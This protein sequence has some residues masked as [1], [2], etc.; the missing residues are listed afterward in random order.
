[1]SVCPVVG[2]VPCP[3]PPPQPQANV[4][5]Q[6][7]EPKGGRSNDL[8]RVRGWGGGDQFGRL[9]GK[10][11]T[12]Y[13]LLCGNTSE[14]DDDLGEFLGAGGRGCLFLPFLFL[15]ALLVLLLLDFPAHSYGV[16][17]KYSTRYN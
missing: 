16:N 12:L 13:T 8:L 15:P 9:D 6:P 1:M 10:L 4:S 5:P 14:V 17:S 7:P 11:G 3:P 2:M